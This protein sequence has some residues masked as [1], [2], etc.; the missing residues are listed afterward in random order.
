MQKTDLY[1]DPN[2]DNTLK[3]AC[4]APIKLGQLMILQCLSLY[5][6]P[7]SKTGTFG[8]TVGLRKPDYSIEL[9]YFRKRSL[10]RH[11]FA[12][13]LSNAPTLNL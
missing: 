10:L 5:K 12:R 2:G 11:A 1:I 9:N 8:L 4:M 6:V 7:V 3:H 13:D